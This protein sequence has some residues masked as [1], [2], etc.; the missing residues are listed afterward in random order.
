MKDRVRRSNICLNSRKGENKKAS[1]CE[2]IMAE[3]F[4][5]S[6]KDTRL[7]IENPGKSQER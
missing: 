4:S 6:I 1:I 3:I 2:E 7:P 5:K